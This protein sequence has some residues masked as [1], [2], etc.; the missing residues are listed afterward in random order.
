MNNQPWS[1][2]LNSYPSITASCQYSSS[3]NFKMPQKN[4]L[5]LPV[6]DGAFICC[7]YGVHIS[8]AM[9]TLRLYRLSPSTPL[10]SHSSALSID[11]HWFDSNSIKNNSKSQKQQNRYKINY[12]MLWTSPS[13]SNKNVLREIPR[14]F[15]ARRQVFGLGAERPRSSRAA[16]TGREITRAAGRENIW[17]FPIPGTPQSSSIYRL[18]LSDCPKKKRIHFV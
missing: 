16:R 17:S 11:P 18:G 3:W 5:F 1:T 13:L 12:D 7:I 15:P 6:H 9:G 8:N 10:I 4:M 2:T 14:A